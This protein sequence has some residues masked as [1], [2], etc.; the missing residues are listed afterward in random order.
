[1][2]DSIELKVQR[3]GEIGLL[4]VE[5]YINNVGGEKVATACSQMIDEG[6]HRFIIN[7]AGCRIVNSVGISF[8][9]EVIEK[10]KSLGGKVAFCCV[11]ATIGKTFRIMGLLQ[12]STLYETEAEAMEALG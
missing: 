1:M 6:V 3:Q 5:G 10:V 11:T 4:A 9:I 12:A 8:L 2:P 7:L